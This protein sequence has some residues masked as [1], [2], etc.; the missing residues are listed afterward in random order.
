MKHNLNRSLPKISLTHNHAHDG[1][2]EVVPETVLSETGVE[3]RG[4]CEDHGMDFGPPR[5]V[6]RA[7]LAIGGD[8]HG[9]PEIAGKER[10]HVV[11][12]V[13]RTAAPDF[14]YH[15]RTFLD[16][17][18]HELMTRPA[19]VAVRHVVQLNVMTGYPVSYICFCYR[20]TGNEKY[21]FT[22]HTFA[23]PKGQVVCFSRLVFPY[24]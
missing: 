13:A 10:R 6:R 5:A 24:P 1:F 19:L 15:V 12:G 11:S 22:T 23:F 21:R 9:V 8:G 3:D 2:R 14:F 4:K 7:Y 20:S 16:A 18:Q 17:P